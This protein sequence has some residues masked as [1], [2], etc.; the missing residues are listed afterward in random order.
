[1]IALTQIMLNYSWNNRPSKLCVYS[2]RSSKTSENLH[3][4]L[5]IVGHTELIDLHSSGVEL[6]TYP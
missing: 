5:V 3:G 1:M 4:F 2:R 6:K